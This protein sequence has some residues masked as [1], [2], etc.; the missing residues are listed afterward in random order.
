MQLRF[1]Y[2]MYY[3]MLPYPISFYIF[4]CRFLNVS[5]SAAI[6]PP[7]PPCVPPTAPAYVLPGAY[8]IANLSMPPLSSFDLFVCFSKWTVPLR[9][10]PMV[11]T[12]L[13]SNRVGVNVAKGQRP[14]RKIYRSSR[15]RVLYF[16]C[17]YRLR[18]CRWRHLLPLGAD[19]RRV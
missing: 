18:Y 17:L 4:R 14:A 9:C 16:P 10:P 15:R 11:Y 8:R 2:S 19:N 6:L 13:L 3:C 1:C 7:P 12:R 5:L